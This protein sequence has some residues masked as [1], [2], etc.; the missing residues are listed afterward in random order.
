MVLYVHLRSKSDSLLPGP[1]RAPASFLRSVCNIRWNDTYEKNENTSDRWRIGIQIFLSISLRVFGNAFRSTF[2]TMYTKVCKG[3]EFKVATEFL[4][5]TWFFSYFSNR[6]NC[7]GDQHLKTRTNM[8]E[9]WSE[10]T[11]VEFC[12]AIRKINRFVAFHPIRFVLLQDLHFVPQSKTWTKRLSTTV[13]QN[14]WRFSKLV[15]RSNGN[16]SKN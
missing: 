4:F 16:D 13:P 12:I 8:V 1:G 2:R 14:S 10:N 3:N 11:S 7:T 9:L 6:P 5:F 15:D